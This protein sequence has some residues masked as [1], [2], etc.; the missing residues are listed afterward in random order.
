MAETRPSDTNDVLRRLPA[1][2]TAVKL[3][4]ILF[5]NVGI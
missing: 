2:H 3:K 1:E 5:E 4:S